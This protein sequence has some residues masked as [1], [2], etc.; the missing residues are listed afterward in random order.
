MAQRISTNGVQHIADAREQDEG[1]WQNVKSQVEIAKLPVLDSDFEVLDMIS[2]LVI[3]RDRIM[4]KN[5]LQ[6]LEDNVGVDLV[7]K[8]SATMTFESADPAFAE[9]KRDCLLGKA[10]ID[11][12]E[13]SCLA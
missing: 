2:H 9:G 13:G 3:L 4:N 5:M 6:V 7:E 1:H 12:G 10:D 8:A 11:A